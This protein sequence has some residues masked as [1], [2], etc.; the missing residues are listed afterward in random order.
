MKDEPVQNTNLMNFVNVEFPMEDLPLFMLVNTAD[1][2]I[3][4][5]EPMDQISSDALANFVGEIVFYDLFDA[6]LSSDPSTD[7]MGAMDK[8]AE[9]YVRKAPPPRND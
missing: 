5:F 1:E 9:A 4:W 8:V 3:H 2:N 6:I 7:M